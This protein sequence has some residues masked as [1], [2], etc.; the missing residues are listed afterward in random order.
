[1]NPDP[2]P[3][4]SP[5]LLILKPRHREML[6][7]CWQYRLL[8]A[9][10]FQH[11]LRLRSRSHVRRLLGELAEKQYVFD[12]PLPHVR[13][14]GAEKLYLLGSRGRRYLARAEGLPVAGYWLP[15]KSRQF[16]YGHLM[17]DLAL[18]RFLIALRVFCNTQQDIRLAEVRT[19]YEIAREPLLAE[20]AENSTAGETTPRVVPDAWVN[21]ELL[22]HGTPHK[23][24]PLMIEIDRGTTWRQVFCQRVAARLSY[25]RPNGL[26]RRIF[27]TDSVRI[28]YL[29]LAGSAR[30]DSLAR[31]AREALVS[32]DR[33]AW[34]GV[35]LFAEASFETMYEE[36]HSLFSDAAWYHPGQ[37]TPVRLFGEETN[38]HGN[39]EGAT[40]PDGLTAGTGGLLAGCAGGS[41]HG[42][43]GGA[44]ESVACLRYS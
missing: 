8:T 10:D 41:A 21:V 20:A 39:R 43:L 17:H 4:A 13:S 3:K 18:A 16:S 36:A 24:S 26:Y 31:W 35:F 29:T 33:E 42:P 14:G 2:P 5:K 40:R 27:A 38:H 37:H 25:I 1:M 7:S 6:E 23:S 30:R 44:D 11:L 15:G 28:L 32:E 19:Q 9:R 22:N 12:V 34:A